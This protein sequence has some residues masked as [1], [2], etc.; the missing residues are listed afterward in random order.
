MLAGPSVS[1]A[2]VVISDFSDGWPPEPPPFSRSEA[3]LAWRA[4]RRG[5]FP[6][7]DPAFSGRAGEPAVIGGNLERLPM[8]AIRKG[9]LLPLNKS[10]GSPLRM[11]R[12]ALVR[13]G[14]ASSGDQF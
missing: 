1:P 7:L 3:A 14:I 6:G 5:P 8:A 11:T 4:G 10:E 2:I 9:A 12:K 13:R